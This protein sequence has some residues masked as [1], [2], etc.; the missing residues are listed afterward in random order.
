MPSFPTTLPTSFS[1]SVLP[2]P[3]G[4][5]ATKVPR[6]QETEDR[7]TWIMLQTKNFLNIV[8]TDQAMSE[9]LRTH[10]NGLAGENRT[11]IQHSIEVPN[12]TKQCVEAMALVPKGI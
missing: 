7:M 6:L 1:V 8:N 2:T 3:Y 12:L 11:I 4:I 10:F 5:D 9:F